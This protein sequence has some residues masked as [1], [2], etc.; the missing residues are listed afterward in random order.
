MSGVELPFRDD[1]D[2]NIYTY[3]G[4]R[5]YVDRE[6]PVKPERL[7]PEVY[8]A[9]TLDAKA[10]YNELRRKYTMRFGVLATSDL[11]QA[12]ERIWK[13]L[14]SNLYLPADVIK[15]GAV[16]DGYAGLGKTTI[17]KTFARK[18]E[19]YV[20]K[21]GKFTTP[22][23]RN[24][25]IPVVHVTLKGLTTSKGL[26]E[27]ICK[28][29]GI[30]SRGHNSEQQLLDAICDA[31][32]RHKILLFVIDDIH[33]LNPRSKNNSNIVNHLKALMSITGATFLYVGIDCEKLGIFRDTDNGNLLASQ[34][35]SRFQH[36]FMFPFRKTGGSWRRLVGSIEAHLVLLDHEPGT[37]ERHERYLFRR[38][39]GNIGSLM[40]LIQ[41]AAFG[42][43]GEEE[44]LDKAILEVTQLDYRASQETA[45]EG[46]TPPEKQKPASTP[47]IPRG[48]GDE[49]EDPM[50]PVEV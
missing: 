5:R 40:N 36:Q 6:P 41:K 3:E 34:I 15:V 33:F 48:N 45:P 26:A 37:L 35:A 8:A 12:H 18:F 23:A 44:R 47:K 43:I 27:S 1:D 20:V 13:Q 2:D 50:V 25:F 24:S 4:W 32:R 31:V 49:P 30:T 39:K 14:K 11:T 19:K 21:V 7:S 17:A 29:L 42:A 9:L 38:T 46:P 16:L 28:F 10:Q 22:E